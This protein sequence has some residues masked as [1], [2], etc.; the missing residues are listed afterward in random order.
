MKFYFIG[1]V[2]CS[3]ALILFAGFA[4]DLNH[5]LDRLESTEDKLIESWDSQSPD[6]SN[7][8]DY[9]KTLVNYEAQ[10]SPNRSSSKRSTSMN[11]NCRKSSAL[12]CQL[13]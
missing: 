8:N 11:P 1:S 9:M 2:C 7:F 6:T 13:R 10:K 12:H 5:D 3:V 4:V